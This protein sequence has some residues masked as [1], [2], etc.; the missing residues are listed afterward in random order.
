V[1]SSGKTLVYALAGL[2]LVGA[3]GA[4]AAA[5]AL[6]GALEPA[7]PA[8]AEPVLFE[9]PRGTSLSAVARRLEGQ[10]LIRDARA[11]GLLARWRGQAERLHAGE[12]ELTSAASAGEILDTLVAGKVK[13]WEVAI[14]EGLRIEAIAARLAEPGLVEADAFVAFAWDPANAEALGVAGPTL[15]GYLFPETYRLPRG[16][17]TREVAKT[18]VDHFLQVWKTLEP[19]A[20]ERGMD[21]REVVRG[22]GGGTWFLN[23]RAGRM[24]SG[25]AAE[26]A[27]FLTMIQDIASPGAA[28]LRAVLEPAP[29]NFLFFVSRNDGTHIFARSYAEHEQNVDRYQRSKRRKKAK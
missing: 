9:V 4:G 6:R 10:G 20:G 17:S 19:L 2:A 1:S 28:A 15:E 22:E 7:G 24:A 14:P 21:M 5:L 25:D 26:Q 11:L 12:Y 3:L 29:T 16:L 18:L 27:P 23:I 13:H 8:D